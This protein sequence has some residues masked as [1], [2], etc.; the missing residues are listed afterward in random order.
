MTDKWNGE[1]RG[2]SDVIYSRLATHY[3][4]C[5]VQSMEFTVEYITERLDSI[6]MS[7]A[8]QDMKLVDILERVY[9]KRIMKGSTDG[10]K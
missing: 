5:G 1:S 2:C 6:L 3:R 7:A 9:D 10:T 8:Q 4:H